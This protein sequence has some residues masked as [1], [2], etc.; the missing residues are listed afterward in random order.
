MERYIT[1]FFAK[2]FTKYSFMVNETEQLSKPPEEVELEFQ[3][4]P[5]STLFSLHLDSKKVLFVILRNSVYHFR[6]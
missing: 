5:P 4:S 3:T 2:T 1:N 6:E